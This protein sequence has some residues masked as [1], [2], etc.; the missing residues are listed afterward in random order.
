MAN[1]KIIRWSAAIFYVF[2]SV[3]ATVNADHHSTPAEEEVRRADQALAA[4]LADRDRDEFAA[5]LAEDAIFFGGKRSHRGRQAVLEAWSVY[6]EPD[7]PTL[8]WEPAEVEV[9]ESESLATSTGPYKVVP[10]ESSARVLEGTYFTVWQRKPEGQWR[11]L[12]DTGTEPEERSS[13]GVTAD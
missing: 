8:S 4:A 13:E 1:I 9:N 2:S 6:F 3:V 5:F 7:G 12:F 10:S 11:V